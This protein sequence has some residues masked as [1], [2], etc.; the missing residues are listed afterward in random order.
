MSTNQRRADELLGYLKTYLANSQTD[1]EKL[2]WY[3]QELVK[4]QPEYKQ[5][6][7]NHQL[8]QLV[9]SLTTAKMYR[10]FL[11]ENFKELG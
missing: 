6:E 8:N 4:V 11:A 10:D 2:R 1:V 5:K 7:L 9:N 3:V